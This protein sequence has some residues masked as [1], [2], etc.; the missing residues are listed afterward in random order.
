VTKAFDLLLAVQLASALLKPAH[1]K[2]HFEPTQVIFFCEFGL[3]IHL[4][5]GLSS[6]HT[7]IILR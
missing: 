6:G 1:Q 7:V 4:I 5:L 2:N 3:F